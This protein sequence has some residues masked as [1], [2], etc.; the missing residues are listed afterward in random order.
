MEE[1]TAEARSSSHRPQ[2]QQQRGTTES[3]SFNSPHRLAAGTTQA[4]TAAH[5][6]HNTH[7]TRSHTDSNADDTADIDATSS[8]RAV[9][10]V[11]D[12][13][14]NRR[15]SGCVERLTNAANA[16]CRRSSDD[17]AA[18]TSHRIIKLINGRA[19]LS[20][21]AGDVVLHCLQQQQCSPIDRACC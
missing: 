18:H 8:G 7:S 1:W 19:E 3:H 14:V 5:S 9:R 2:T 20:G 6:A 12:S 11:D 13:G 10:S 17:W 21:T 15:R 4:H 16:E